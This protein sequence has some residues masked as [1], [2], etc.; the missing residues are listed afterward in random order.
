MD[1][2]FT[3]QR[4]LEQIIKDTF[5]MARRYANGRQTY[6]TWVINQSLDKLAELGIQIDDDHVLVQ[7]GNSS[8]KYLDT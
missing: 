6:A 8:E 7:D 2:T 3:K 1:E 5:W 4:Q